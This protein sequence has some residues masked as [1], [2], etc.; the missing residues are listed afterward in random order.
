MRE[1]R[2]QRSSRGGEPGWSEGSREHLG[3]SEQRGEYWEMR[4]ER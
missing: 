4:T 3:E 1:E 2:V